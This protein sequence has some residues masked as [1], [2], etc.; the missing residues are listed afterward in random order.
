MVEIRNEAK[1]AVLKLVEDGVA[2]YVYVTDLMA[3]IWDDYI[4]EIIGNVYTRELLK[5]LQYTD[6]QIFHMMVQLQVGRSEYI[7]NDYREVMYE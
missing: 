6:T 2:S 1:G 3:K 7:K 4:R 5:D